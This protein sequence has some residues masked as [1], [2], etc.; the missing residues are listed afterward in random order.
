MYM[1]VWNYHCCVIDNPMFMKGPEKHECVLDLLGP[2]KRIFLLI[3]NKLSWADLEKQM[4]SCLTGKI[5]P[6]RNAWY[7][8]TQ[9]S[10]LCLQIF[11][12]LLWELKYFTKNWDS[13]VFCPLSPNTR[14]S[15]AES[16]SRAKAFSCW[17]PTL[18][19]S[20]L[21]LQWCSAF[22][23]CPWGSYGGLWLWPTSENSLILA[24]V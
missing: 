17:L 6:P 8:Q 3:W 13:G 15:K 14:K 20:R 1:A 10:W 23:N 21:H 16:K 4:V 5:S 11:W 2:Q 19:S 18:R 24:S 7:F 9:N 22:Y 12:M